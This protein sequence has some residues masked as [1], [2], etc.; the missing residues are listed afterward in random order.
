MST[1]ARNLLGLGLL[2]LYALGTSGCQ[3]GKSDGESRRK[4]DDES[5]PPAL[6]N[7]INVG[8]GDLTAYSTTLP[9]RPVWK[10]KWKSARIQ[11]GKKENSGDNQNSLGEVSD[12][13]GLIFP[14]NQAAV[15]FSSASGSG[16][17][18][19]GQLFLRENVTIF[20][21][22]LKA[23]LRSDVVHYDASAKIV[24]AKGNVRVTSEDGTLTTNQ[25]LW[26]TPDLKIVGT[27]DEFLRLRSALSSQ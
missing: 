18:A 14:E 21:P 23:T 5:H 3:S 8:P 11:P 16:D 26:A 15:P 20:S 9:R 1:S 4:P 27:K 19:K 22:T 12:A 7:A 10:L 25:E 17:Q 13:S 6:E 2:I 24:V